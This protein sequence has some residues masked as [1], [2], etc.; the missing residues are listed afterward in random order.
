MTNW[1]K[2]RL[3]KSLAQLISYSVVLP[4]TSQTENTFLDV[5]H[6]Q[7]RS[8]NRNP[9]PHHSDPQC[10]S[11]ACSRE[12]NEVGKG[13]WKS[14][15]ISVQL[16]WALSSWALT[17]PKAGDSTTSS[18]KFFLCLTV[19]RVGFFMFWQECFF[20]MTSRS[21]CCYCFSLSHS[22]KSLPPISLQTLPQAT[23]A[24]IPNPLHAEKQRNF[25][26]LLFLLS[27]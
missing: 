8:F 12:K 27:K 20:P 24:L 15:L 17:F 2:H 4:S 13:S 18:D 3:G 14:L 23:E 21:T 5:V 16:L 1:Q 25:L 19:L 26:M 6:P 22:T 9:L 10:N 11:S 7:T